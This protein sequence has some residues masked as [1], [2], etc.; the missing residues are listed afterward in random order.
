MKMPTLI[1]PGFEESDNSLNPLGRTTW[2]PDGSGHAAHIEPGGHSGSYRLT[3]SS[4]QAYLVSTSQTLTGLVEGWYTLRAWVRSS[5][6][7]QAAYIGL[8]DCGGAERKAYLPV[9]PADKW[10][11]IVVSA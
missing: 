10:I 9:T 5:G 3:H 4:A 1:N 8:K 6:G 7:Q 11:Q 2:A